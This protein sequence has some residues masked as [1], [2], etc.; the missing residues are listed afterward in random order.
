MM[1][2]SRPDMYNTVCNL[3]RHMTRATQVHYD[4][5]L[6]MMKYVNDTSERVP[7]SK[8]NAKVG[9]KQGTQVHYQ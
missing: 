9:Q 7:C 4:A 8:S 3:A 2:Y 5:M 6:R 1:Q